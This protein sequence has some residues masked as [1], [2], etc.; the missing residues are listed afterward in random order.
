MERMFRDIPQ[1][2]NPQPGHITANT[3]GNSAFLLQPFPS[4]AIDSQ[5]I[6]LALGAVQGQ[7]QVCDELLT[8]GMLA[9][10]PFQL[11]DEF[12]VPAESKV[13][14]DP[15]VE[16]AYPLLIKPP[17]LLVHDEPIDIGIGWPSPQTE[18]F[19]EALCCLARLEAFESFRAVA[20]R[21]LEQ[22]AVDLLRLDRQVVP[23]RTMRQAGFLP[24]SPVGLEKLAQDGDVLLQRI[25]R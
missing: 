12:G 23:T 18:A 10:Q 19:P 2:P 3:Y 22:P 8:R 11:T 21:F 5:C 7:H 25:Q 1:G 16:G 15:Q 4:V 9:H 6:P 24:G 14:L 20:Q 13:G 17:S